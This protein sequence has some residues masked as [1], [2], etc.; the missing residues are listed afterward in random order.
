LEMR[1]GHPLRLHQQALLTI[2]S[3]DRMRKNYVGTSER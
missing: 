1:E 2:L 3:S